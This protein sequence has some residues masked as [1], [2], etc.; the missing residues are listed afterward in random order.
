MDP[1]AYRRDDDI[2]YYSISMETQIRATYCRVVYVL[3]Q[4]I[5][6]SEF[7]EELEYLKSVQINLHSKIIVSIISNKYY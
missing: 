7:S 2:E 5:S 3:T 1:T 4:I 6:Y